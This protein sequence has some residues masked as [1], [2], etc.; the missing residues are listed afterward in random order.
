MAQVRLLGQTDDNEALRRD[1]DTHDRSSI[2]F[3]MFFTTSG[4]GLTE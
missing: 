3:N 4:L 2:L 1:L